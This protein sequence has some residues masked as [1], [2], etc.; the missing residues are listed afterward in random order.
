MSIENSTPV[1]VA[2]HYIEVDES[3]KKMGRY[4]A[5]TQKTTDSAQVTD[6]LDK[7]GSI[8]LY[9]AEQEIDSAMMIE[10]GMYAES[11]LGDASNQAPE[12]V[13]E[14]VVLKN[15]G[16]ES[17]NKLVEA[18]LRLVVSIVNS[19]KRQPYFDRFSFWDMVQVGNEALIRAAEKY[20]YKRGFK[21]ST[22]AT[23]VIRDALAKYAPMGRPLSMSSNTHEKIMKIQG[24]ASRLYMETGRHPSNDE[25]AQEL[26]MRPGT[27][28]DLLLSAREPLEMDKV[29]ASER[30]DGQNQTFGE[31]IEDGDSEWLG[32]Q[33]A[34]QEMYDATQRL[35]DEL[36]PEDRAL[37]NDKQGFNSEYR[38]Y[39]NA[40]LMEKYGLSKSQLERRLK[41]VTES[42]RLSYEAAEMDAHLFNAVS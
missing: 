2:A 21:F 35:L 11:L 16:V 4:D 29:A 18:N 37:V 5:F 28:R 13:D 27:V 40:E 12:G 38:C 26:K 24:V 6:Y 10:A 14:L 22:M 39:S 41:K 7:I 42:L 20:D 1:D 3:F 17:R 33:M 32:E 23:W 34:R 8:G 30:F 36:S 25:L 31:L 9:N 19:K 15:A